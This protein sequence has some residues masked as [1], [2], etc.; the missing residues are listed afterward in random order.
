MT[1][2]IPQSARRLLSPV[3]RPLIGFFKRRA[4]AG[5][6]IS[7]LKTGGIGLSY[8]GMAPEPGK[9]AAGGRVKLTHLNELFPE[10]KSR[11]N[12]LYLVS[13]A[14]PPYAGEWLRICRKAG[15]KIVWNQNGV[16]YPAWAGQAYEK[17]NA[18]MRTLIHQSDFV[19]Y[20]SEFCKASADKFLGT[21]AGPGKIIYNCVDTAFFTPGT[22]S[23]PPSPVRLLVMGSHHQ[24]QR[25]T[26]AL[27]TLSLLIRRNIPAQIKI[28]GRLAWPGAE[29]EIRSHIKALNLDKHVDLAGPY[30]QEKAPDIYRAAQILLHFK[31]N[32]PCPTVPI[33]AMSCGVPVVGSGSGGVPELL[34]NQGGV[35]ID[36]PRGWEQAYYPDP[37]SAAEAVTSIMDNW[38][39]WSLQARRRAVEHF[40][41]EKWL[42]DHEQIFREIAGAN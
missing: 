42:K 22:D 14:L 7:L 21:F 37:E 12:I 19:I 24:A 38:S 17:V 23:L 26:M 25:V 18:P 34:G 5:Q 30:L 28:A 32:D 2:Y 41:K 20:Q 1:I 39:D 13:S 16:G 31:Y 40:G 3:V 35:T 33:E 29:K 15:I 36:V 27:E 11:F 4:I 8:A 10:Q 9:L 6:E